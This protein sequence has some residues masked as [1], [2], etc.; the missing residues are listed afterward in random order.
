[1]TQAISSKPTYAE[2]LNEAR[3]YRTSL[4]SL[5]SVG[6]AL[7][8]S[9]SMEDDSSNGFKMLTEDVLE[10][11]DHQGDLTAVEG[12]TEP[13]AV[14]ELIMQDV[15]T[16][17]LTEIEEIERAL[18]AKADAEEPVPFTTRD[19]MTAASMESVY[20]VEM[21]DLMLTHARTV[22]TLASLEA[23]PIEV[24]R[25][26]V[27]ELAE[28]MKP[29]LEGLGISLEEL[30]E[31]QVLGEMADAVQRIET[32]VEKA[33]ETATDELNTAQQEAASVGTDGADPL[34]DV[35][36]SHRA[37]NQSGAQLDEGVSVTTVPNDSASATGDEQAADDMSEDSNG[38]DLDGAVEASEDTSEVEGG[39]DDV[40]S[41]VE[42]DL[43]MV[44]GENDGGEVA[45]AEGTADA[46]EE[47]ADVDAEAEENLLDGEDKDKDDEEEEE[48]D[49]NLSLESL[50][51]PVVIEKLSDVTENFDMV[52]DNV[53]TI[54]TSLD[55]LNLLTEKGKEAL[56]AGVDENFVM[57]SD[58]FVPETADVL[59]RNYPVWA[60]AAIRDGGCNVR[61]LLALVNN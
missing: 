45:D 56:L 31:T 46:S 32:L 8:I 48:E 59:V 9:P 21:L 49:E 4:E 38:L 40:A 10:Q 33:H 60:A 11:A 14:V 12:V 50:P 51:E 7:L 61:A 2:L 58:M 19:A 18:E 43:D 37:E 20:K 42:G 28:Y 24:V 22:R 27:I 41:D 30:A 55:G 5:M 47:G 16:P 6:R 54:M 15:L 44:E 53:A 25:P 23:A 52:R 39:T 34:G 17:R 57:T 3:G 36:E 1:M 13:K 26:A 29:S 35:I